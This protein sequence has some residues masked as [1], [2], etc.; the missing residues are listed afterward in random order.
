[1]DEVDLAGFRPLPAERPD[2]VEAMHKA[3]AGK[4]NVSLALDSGV[5][6]HFRAMGPDWPA[7]INAAL[8]EVVR[9][10]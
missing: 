3:R 1:M 9:V 7:R 8:R 4:T 10:Q 2:I 5:V 6:E